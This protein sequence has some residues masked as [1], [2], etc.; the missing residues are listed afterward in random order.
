MNNKNNNKGNILHQYY[1]QQEQSD[2]KIGI[3]Q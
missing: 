2:Y 1:M 3:F